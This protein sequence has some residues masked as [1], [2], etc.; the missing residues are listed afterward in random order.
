[1]QVVEAV[2]T[3]ATGAGEVQHLVD[4]FTSRLTDW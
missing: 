1:V 2:P 4:F 3:A